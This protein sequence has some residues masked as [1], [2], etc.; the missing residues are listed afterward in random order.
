MISDGIA[1]GSIN[2]DEAENYRAIIEN[3]FTGTGVA[4][5]FDDSK[6]IINERS[7]IGSGGKIL[8]P[9]RIVIDSDTVTV[10]DYKYSLFDDVSEADMQ[11]YVAQ[12][13]EYVTLLTEVFPEKEVKG[14]LLW[15]KNK[16]VLQDV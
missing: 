10:V 15:L 11:K 2:K 6:E 8:R 9:D 3:I 7:F 16:I 13:S 12:V 14:K 4:G 1:S 5:L